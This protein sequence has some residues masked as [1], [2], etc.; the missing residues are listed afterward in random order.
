M[1][2]FV[3]TYEGHINTSLR[4]YIGKHINQKSFFAD[5]KAYKKASEEY[6]QRHSAPTAIK[7]KSYQIVKDFEDTYRVTPFEGKLT[8]NM[9]KEYKRYA[10]NLETIKSSNSTIKGAEKIYNY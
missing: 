3:T 6:D 2:A 9:F 10:K 7:P 4:K 8:Y 5:Y 1:Q